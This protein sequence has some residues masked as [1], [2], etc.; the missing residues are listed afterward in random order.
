M[1]QQVSTVK[2]STQKIVF[3]MRTLIFKFSVIFCVDDM[4]KKVTRISSFKKRINEILRLKF[5]LFYAL[6]HL[7][8][9]AF[10]SD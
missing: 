3:I 6:N 9:L 5:N 10:S 2:C 7:T 1:V 8:F 4:R